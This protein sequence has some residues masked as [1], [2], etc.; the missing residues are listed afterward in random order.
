MDR[1]VSMVLVI[2]IAITVVFSIFTD[3]VTARAEDEGWLWPVPGVQTV[4]YSHYTSHPAI[5]ISPGTYIVATKSGTVYAL[6][7][8]CPHDYG[9]PTVNGV[10]Q[11]C[12]C[13]KNNSSGNYIQIQHD[14]G[15]YAAYLHLR[16][17]ITLKKGDYVKQGDVIGVMGSTGKSS[18]KHLHFSLSINPSY[19]LFSAT[20]LN[21]PDVLAY[22]YGP[23]NVPS[24]PPPA[25]TP[26]VPSNPTTPTIPTSHS[27]GTHSQT[28]L[29]VDQAAVNTK[30][31]L[32]SWNKL[33]D[34]DS[35]DLAVYNQNGILEYE[36]KGLTDTFYRV[37]LKVGGYYA[38][39][40]SVCSTHTKRVA[41]ERKSFDVTVG[42]PSVSRVGTYNGNAYYLLDDTYSWSGAA[43]AASM[44]GGHLVYINSAEEYSV[45]KE[46]LTTAPL[47]SYWIGATDKGR[48]KNDFI[49]LDGSK[50]TFT[51]WDSS[52]L[53]GN[54]Y[55]GGYAAINSKTGLWTVLSEQGRIEGLG[56]IVEVEGAYSVPVSEIKFN[57]NT[58]SLAPGNSVRVST[59][60]LPANASDKSLSWSSLD[61]RYATVDENGMITAKPEG[62]GKTVEIQARAKDGSGITGSINVSIAALVTEIRVDSTQISIPVGSRYTINAT[63]LPEF[64][65][66]KGINWMSSNAS[67]ASV[68]SK[69]EIT[70]LAEGVGK[71][72]TIMGIAKDGSNVSVKTTVRISAQSIPV[73]SIKLNKSKVSLY[74]DQIFM[75]QTTVNPKN[76]DNRSITF[77]S[78]NNRYAT[79]DSTGRVTALKAGA[80]KTVTITASSA[81]DS[82]KSA[83][84]VVTINT[85]VTKLKLTSSKERLSVGKSLTIKADISPAKATNKKVNWKVSNSSYAKIDT[86]G[87]LTALKEGKGKT[88]TVTA[89]SAFDKSIKDTI[90]IKLI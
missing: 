15:T 40:T 18:G 22:S 47:S 44:I 5:D 73:T 49:W 27:S 89:S 84:L 32:F 80:G 31:V 39:V 30:G 13:P 57:S 45:I 90:K 53:T 35:Y 60:V 2:V 56:Y 65:K 74:P 62:V 46:M 67:Y 61:S 29:T 82:K 59:T 68:N 25:Y 87:K 83:T 33:L 79:V 66:D 17:G 75:L 63:V 34:S 50:P 21:T 78:S 48:A 6:S 38:V 70:A 20:I 55:N 16:Q 64:A 1:S 54:N 4:T 81:E 85:P 58:V 3:G 86:K 10:I 77:S 37:N 28:V 69:G 23:Y 19:W 14:D 71:T 9:K 8:D 51:A 11:N 26:T 42:S 12:P 76:A 52:A 72:V 88:V 7:D 41:S 43:V 36:K 24:T